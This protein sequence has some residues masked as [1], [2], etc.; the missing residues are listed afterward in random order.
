MQEIINLFYEAEKL[1]KE[2]KYDDSLYKYK[3]IIKIKPN[4][5]PVLNNIA[6]I[7]E[8]TENFKKAEEYYEKCYKINPKE[9]TIINNLANIYYKQYKY[10]KAKPL[11]EISININEKQI[12]IINKAIISNLGLNY[13]L[14]AK[15][16]CE[17][18]FETAS[19]D[20]LFC[21]LYGKILIKL[22]MHK[23]GLEFLKKGT[24]FI[25]FQNNKKPNIISR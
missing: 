8:T 24:G 23:E 20:Q 10:F 18:Y 14:E 7:Y 15:N 5:F 4:L 22:N 21:T 9:L 19:D 3:E 16:I 17:K 25:E 2:K 1:F 13:I 6:L 12:K 11:F